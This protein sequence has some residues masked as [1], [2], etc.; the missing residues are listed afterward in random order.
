MEIKHF[1]F[2][3]SEN[4]RFVKIIRIVFGVVCIAVAIYWFSFNIKSLK[5][6]GTLWITI[7][8]L[9]GFGFYQIWSGLGRATR[10]I[11]ITPDYIRL[12]KNPILPPLKMSS[13]EIEKIELFPL[14]LIFFLKSKKRILLRFGTTY[15][16]IN[17]KIK[18]EILSFAESNNIPLEIVEEKI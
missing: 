12:K 17:E 2:G 11:E 15:H 4:N 10:F 5:A 3:T 7:I 16:E 1:S 18:D 14:N 8:F 13:G 9:T 6:D